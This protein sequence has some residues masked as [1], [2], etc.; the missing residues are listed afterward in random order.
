MNTNCILFDTIS[1]LTYIALRNNLCFFVYAN[2]VK[3]I[4]ALYDGF[5]V[6]PPSSR[7]VGEGNGDAALLNGHLAQGCNCQQGCSIVGIN[8]S[9]GAILDSLDEGAA[10]QPIHSVGVRTQA[11]LYLFYLQM[12]RMPVGKM[13]FP[14]IIV[15]HNILF[16]MIKEENV[17]VIGIHSPGSPDGVVPAI[18]CPGECGVKANID[19]LSLLGGQN[20]GDNV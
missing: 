12:K 18:V 1:V 10:D 6:L 13:H 17:F 5:P 16:H 4:L 14:D 2:L 7:E 19:G 15:M 20:G 11:I 9:V 3:T 8:G